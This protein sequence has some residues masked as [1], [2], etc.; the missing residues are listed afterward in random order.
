MS[1]AIG[2]EPF[3]AGIEDFFPLLVFGFI[4]WISARRARKNRRN[5]AGQGAARSPRPAGASKAIN[6]AEEVD[7]FEVIRQMLF[8]EIELPPMSAPQ[9]TQPETFSMED[10]SG[11]PPGVAEWKVENLPPLSP[12][13]K[14]VLSVLLREEVMNGHASK[15]SSV[16][17]A[18]S[19]PGRPALHLSQTSRRELRR[20]VLWAEVL[21]PPVALRDA[22]R[23]PY[24]SATRHC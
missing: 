16:V 23:S 21:A 20:A 11:A 8:G 15:V 17:V 18:Q 13:E 24:K 3:R 7:P 14:V 12:S 5:Q 19:E 22:S 4:W 1:L 6:G 10:F 2:L 9:P